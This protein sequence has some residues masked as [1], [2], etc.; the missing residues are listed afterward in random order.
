MKLLD[1]QMDS[2]FSEDYSPLSKKA[3]RLQTTT[4]TIIPTRIS[5]VQ[6]MG[7]FLRAT[8]L[9]ALSAQ[10]RRKS[11]K[12]PAFNTPPCTSTNSYLSSL[13]FSSLYTFFYFS[14]SFSLFQTSFISMHF[15]LTSKKFF[16][17]DATK[18]SNFMS[19][20]LFSTKI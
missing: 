20:A 12:A 8:S 14:L 15:F 6:F 19:I 16:R 1:K 5:L 7:R 11:T 18:F 2:I 17:V 10:I 13:L 3:E 4:H 9:G